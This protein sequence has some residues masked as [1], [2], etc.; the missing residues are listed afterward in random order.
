[1]MK[2][3]APLK[4]LFLE[5]LHI[6]IT[7]ENESITIESEDDSVFVCLS[8]GPQTTNL[9]SVNLAGSESSKDEGVPFF[10]LVSGH[11]DPGI[12]LRYV[13]GAEGLPELTDSSRGSLFGQSWWRRVI[14]HSQDYILHWDRQLTDRLAESYRNFVV[15]EGFSLLID[16][17][18]KVST[19]SKVLHA[20]SWPIAII[21]KAA[22]LDNPWAM[23]LEKAQE[24]G[25][26]L[27]NMLIASQFKEIEVDDAVKIIR[28]KPITLI[29]F[30]FGAR[31]FNALFVLVFRWTTPYLTSPSPL[32][33]SVE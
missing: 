3:T 23:C 6:P 21:E 9:S 10:I 17:L 4:E 26:S 7:I 18:V 28:G 27:A 32:I 8:T 33:V 13:W 12:D 14:P 1:M 16:E 19:V 29:G 20:A 25:E 11:C 22:E 5:P 31:F 15:H 24:A 30:G 2:R